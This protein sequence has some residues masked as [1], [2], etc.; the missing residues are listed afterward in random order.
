MPL[1]Q[2]KVSVV[3]TPDKQDAIV[4][5]AS[6]VLARDTGKPETYCMVVFET[7]A[8]ALG[9]KAGPAAFVDIR[10]I[11]GLTREVNNR[12]AKSFCD[13]LEARLGI[14]QDRVYLN[15]TDVAAQNWG[16]KG[17]TFG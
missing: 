9:G 4:A 16:M 11:G 12:L 2:L 1:V 7:A 17:A 10:G 5:E 15:F 13:L 3:T 6:R 14:P 8:I